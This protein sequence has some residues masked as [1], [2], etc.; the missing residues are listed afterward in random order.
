M[1]PRCLEITLI[2]G[3]IPFDIVVRRVL[4][5]PGLGH[6]EIQHFRDGRPGVREIA[7][8]SIATPVGRGN[9]CLST[10]NQ[11]AIHLVED[12]YA[13]LASEVLEYMTHVDFV[14]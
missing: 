7:I 5:P 1:A 9:R 8:S 3:R 10:R 11:D 14:N 12:L 6:V 4:Q 2:S 13:L